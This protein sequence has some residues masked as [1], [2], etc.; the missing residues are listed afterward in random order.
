M[1]KIGLTTFV[2]VVFTILILGF[3]YINYQSD[4]DSINSLNVNLIDLKKPFEIISNVSDTSFRLNF[5]VEINNPSDR[6]IVDLSTDFKIYI[7]DNYV[8]E[9]NFSKV[10]I[11]NNSNI[12]KDVNVILYY[13]G[14]TDAVFFLIK[15]IIYKEEINL[16]IKGTIYAKALFGL[17]I[18]EQNYTATKT[19]Q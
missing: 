13:S 5:D 7:E 11:P 16:E 4:I 3:S 1:R 6:D 17:S 9:G 10:H 19:Y 12:S 14:L 2:L 15:N 18:I 8:G